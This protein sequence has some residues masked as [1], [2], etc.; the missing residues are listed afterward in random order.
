M[1]GVLEMSSN[2]LNSNSK[3]LLR[4]A[5]INKYFGKVHALKDIDFK[6]S[7]AENVGLG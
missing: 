5:G 4:M 2:E 1:R 3:E 7:E 6:I